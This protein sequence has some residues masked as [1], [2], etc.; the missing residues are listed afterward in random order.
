MVQAL[1]PSLWDRC[2]DMSSLW[3]RNEDYRFDRRK[4]SRSEDLGTPWSLSQ[5]T[6]NSPFSD[7][8][9][10]CELNLLQGDLAVL[11][12]FHW[13]WDEL[14]SLEGREDQFSYL[15][16]ISDLG[17]DEKRKDNG[18]SRHNWSVKKSH[19][20]SYLLF[21]IFWKL[22]FKLD[23]RLYQIEKLIASWFVANRNQGRDITPRQSPLSRRL[24]AAKASK[25]AAGFPFQPLCPSVYYGGR[26]TT[27]AHEPRGTQWN[28]EFFEYLWCFFLECRVALKISVS[29]CLTTIFLAPIDL[30][31]H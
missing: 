1:E 6:T 25:I 9:T 20:F 13:V 17:G 31:S 4:G 16:S 26:K 8:N 2:F 11:Y 15:L 29:L 23:T 24:R 19:Y 30:V 7:P 5:T 10:V 14:A 28:L 12:L 18:K 22:I 21:P 3:R 27:P